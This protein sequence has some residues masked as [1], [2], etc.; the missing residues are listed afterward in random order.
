MSVQL[1]PIHLRF[2]MIG[3]ALKWKFVLYNEIWAEHKAINAHTHTA[4][5]DNI[6]IKDVL[7]V[8]YTFFRL[9]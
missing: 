2:R 7:H 5:T 4:K 1:K 8:R 9:E 6:T 3:K